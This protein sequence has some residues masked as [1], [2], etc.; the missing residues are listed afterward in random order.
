MSEQIYGLADADALFVPEQYLPTQ[1]APARRDSL[2]CGEKALMLAVLED[3][4]RCLDARTRSGRRQAC[5]AERWVRA[6]DA[7]WPFSFVNVCSYLEIDERRLR[8][9][10][11]ARVAR[12]RA[13]GEGPRYRRHLRRKPA[14]ARIRVASEPC[15]VETDELPR[16]AVQG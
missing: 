7:E 16:R 3:A 1:V 15:A 10:L 13:G 2:I 5:E 6:K 9:E 4:V 14:R 12:R 8:A 11:L